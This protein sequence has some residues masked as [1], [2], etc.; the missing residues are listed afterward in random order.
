MN[1]IINIIRNA[2]PDKQYVYLMYRYRMGKK[3]NLKHPKTYN[4]KLQWLKLYYHVPEYS[5]LVDKFL[6]KHKVA[7][8]I[9]KK[10]IIPTYGVWNKFDEI[11]FNNL[12][13]KFVLKCTHDSGGIVICQ[14]KQRF[15]QKRAKEIIELSLKTNYYKLGREW[16]YKSVKP[17]II[18]EKYMEDSVT[19]EL[20]DYKFF[21]F[22]GRVRFLFVATD[23]QKH[24]DTKF[25][26]F[27]AEYKHLNIIQGHPNAKTIPEKPKNF[28]LMKS[29][30]EKLSADM[31]HVRVDF[32]EVDGNVFFGELTFFHH[33][34]WTPF[35]PEKWD[36]IFGKHLILPDIKK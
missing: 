5:T 25:D 11:D 22:N 13:N 19:N 31:P 35:K 27:D 14:D 34:G 23:R 7:S 10:Y 29:L 6:V 2:I 28:T 8:I 24:E 3:L 36:Y 16:P 1:K 12:P 9:G 18:A 17:R 33:G 26:F 20:R 21:C 15:D 30:A 32:Y 4:E